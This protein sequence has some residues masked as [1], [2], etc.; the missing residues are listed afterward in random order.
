MGLFDIF[1]KKPLVFEQKCIV[2]G[3]HYLDNNFSNPDN[4]KINNLRALEDE[5]TWVR[6]IEDS[7]GNNKFKLHFFGHFENGI[8]TSKGELPI[9]VKAIST[10][11]QQEITL[12]D[13]A[14]HGYNA[15]FWQ[16][17]SSKIDT[18]VIDNELSIYEQTDFEI[19]LRLRYS[20][21]VKKEFDSDL[22]QNGFV[23]NNRGENL[24][25]SGFQNGF[26]SIE[27]FIF[28]S[29]GKIAQIVAEETA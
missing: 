18:R 19:V 22:K 3:P 13:G 14:K 9:I 12:F 17:F 20:L 25:A 6:Q 16:E 8:I 4:I 1:K 26:D 23:T 5:Q 21:E 28:T 2:K 27:V 24:D 29:N 11:T 7:E 15:V 10:Q